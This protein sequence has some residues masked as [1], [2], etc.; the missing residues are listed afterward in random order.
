M[1]LVACLALGFAVAACMQQE[2]PPPSPAA[3]ME[4]AAKGLTIAEKWCAD[5]HVV[6]AEQKRVRRPEMHAPP[7]AAVVARPE[8]DA[9]YL[10]RFMDVQ[11]LPM[12]TYRLYSDEKADVVA[13]LLSLKPGR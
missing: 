13:Y 5:C 3:R 7:F 12:T 9:G 11:H 10:S 8:V 1:R 4:S 6:K 2:P